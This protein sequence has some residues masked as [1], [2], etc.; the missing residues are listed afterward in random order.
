M[1]R[2]IVIEGGSVSQEKRRREPHAQ[3]VCR[4]SVDPA[5]RHLTCYWTVLSDG[6]DAY[7]PWATRSYAVH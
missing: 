1:T 4:W 7:E 3:L 5:S 2:P 6:M